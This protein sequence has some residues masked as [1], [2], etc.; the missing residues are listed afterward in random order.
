M[1][2]TQND[3]FRGL[4]GTLGVKAP[5]LV[6]TTT[7]IT[8]SGE[9]TIDGVLTSA[10]RVLVKAQTTV[11]QNGIYLSGTGAWAREPDFDGPLDAVQGTL[12]PVSS[13]GTNQSQS[14]WMLTTADPVIGTSNL[15]FEVW[16]SPLYYGTKS[17]CLLATTAN[18]TLSGEQTVDG[19]LTSVSRIL[20]K[21]QTTASQNGIYYTGASTW[22]RA[23]DFAPDVLQGTIVPVASGTANGTSAWMLTTAD[24]VIGTSSLTFKAWITPLVQTIT[25]A[26]TIDWDVYKGQS[27]LV[28]LTGNI[29]IN[30]PTN[31]RAGEAYA[32]KI[33]QGGAGSYTVTWGS[34]FKWPGGVAPTLSTPVGSHDVLSFLTF[35]GTRL[36]GV[37]QKAFA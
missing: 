14:L 24:P 36:E 12:V 13:G 19:V 1:A 28:T 20:V 9:Q 16:L 22:S 35:D 7:N 11:S 25:Y 18:V 3:R 26:A 23:G 21:N 31:I 8:L 37:G 10:D 6:A 29:T 33:I 5:C 34:S 30:N 27:A 17:P 32:L 4:T 15:T 2:T